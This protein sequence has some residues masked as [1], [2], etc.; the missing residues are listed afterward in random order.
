MT[1]VDLRVK[2]ADYHNELSRYRFDV[3]LRTSPVA[4]DPWVGAVEMP[5]GPDGAAQLAAALA[6]PRPPRLRVTG[7]SNA[8]LAGDLRILSALEG[9]PAAPRGVDPQDVAVLAERHGYRLAA[10]WSGTGSAGELDLLLA[11]DVT[12]TG[13]Y[14]PGRTGAGVEAYANTPAGF[15]DV[16]ALMKSLRSFVAQRL[17]DYMVPAAFVPLDR[18]PV[19][20]SGKLDRAAMP[21]PDFAALTGTAAP[22]TSSERVLCDLVAEVLGLPSR[23][24]RRRLLRPRRR[25][26]RLDPAGHRGPARRAW[27]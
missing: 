4:A 16:G 5:W 21:A 11:T 3:V 23:R 7:V 18:L 19:L 20:P 26:H 1:A 9:R 17:P 6:G 10:T 15:R 22:R 24:R 25:Q 8:R 13:V 12:P 2:D 27:R 14:R